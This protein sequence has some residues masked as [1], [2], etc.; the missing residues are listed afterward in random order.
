M[1]FFYNGPTPPSGVFDDLLATAQVSNNVGT[2][3]F[4]KFVESVTTLQISPRGSYRSVSIT[5][6]TVPL[7]EQIVDQLNVSIRLSTL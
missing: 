1:V 4:P 6:Y 3:T 7:I 5:D 2:N